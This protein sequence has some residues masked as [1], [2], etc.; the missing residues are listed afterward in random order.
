MNFKPQRR[1]SF[2]LALVDCN[3]HRTYNF[4]DF[5]RLVGYITPQ[6]DIREV[7]NI[8]LEKE[9]LV[10]KEKIL[11]VKYYKI[12][13]KLLIKLIKTFDTTIKYTNYFTNTGIVWAT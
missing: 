2:I 8:L 9:I 11:G 7:A 12:N 4:A 1:L 6:P 10:F 13:R 5:E 3:K